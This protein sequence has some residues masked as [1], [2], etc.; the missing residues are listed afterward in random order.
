MTLI[1]QNQDFYNLIKE[2][3]DDY[4]VKV[5]NYDLF[6]H[7][8]INEIFKKDENGKYI[9]HPKEKWEEYIKDTDNVY[10]TPLPNQIDMESG[11][12]NC[13]N[14]KAVSLASTPFT[15]IHITFY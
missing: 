13:R 4:G 2:W 8:T 5:G 12:F 7:K 6:T 9:N 14:S 1:E 3:C 10:E 11:I 15:E